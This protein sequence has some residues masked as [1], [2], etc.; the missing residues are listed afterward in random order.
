M[1]ITVKRT[2]NVLILELNGRLL[3]SSAEFFRDTLDHH[4]V[5]GE[6]KILIDLR[7]LT[8]SD[9]AEARELVSTSILLRNSAGALKFLLQAERVRDIF[10]VFEDER[11]AVRSFE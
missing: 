7:G 5:V 1:L 10:E 2:E 8:S 3:S 11:E 6:R 4:V 9:V